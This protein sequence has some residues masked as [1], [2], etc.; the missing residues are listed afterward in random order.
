M[1]KYPPK[2]SMPK[3]DCIAVFHAQMYAIGS[4]HETE[5]PQ[6]AA[7]KAFAQATRHACNH[8]V[9]AQATRMTCQQ[10]GTEDLS[11]AVRSPLKNTRASCA[12]GRRLRTRS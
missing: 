10:I 6:I 4:K 5:S 3:G 1:P 9:L 12:R 11:R 2:L 8:E 7:R